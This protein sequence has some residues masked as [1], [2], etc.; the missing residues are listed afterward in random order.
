MNSSGGS[1]FMA[2]QSRS[3]QGPL[4]QRYCPAAGLVAAD[5]AAAALVPAAAEGPLFFRPMVTITRP[6]VTT[7][8]TTMVMIQPLDT[9]R[10]TV[11]GRCA[12]LGS[13]VRSVVSGSLILYSHGKTTGVRRRV[14]KPAPA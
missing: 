7:S 13:G 11:A 8:S 3:P 2:R 14:G 12:G 1:T 10:W 5:A 4:G 6:Q 9:C